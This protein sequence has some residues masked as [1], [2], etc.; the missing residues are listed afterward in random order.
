MTGPSRRQ[1][2]GGVIGAALAMPAR[3]SGSEDVTTVRVANGGP[4]TPISPFVY[5]SNEVGTM[6]GGRP[7]AELDRLAGVTARRFGGNLATT[8]NWTSNAQNAGKDYRHANVDILSDAIGVPAALRNRPGAVIAHTHESSLAMGAITIVTLPVAGYVAADM[9][10]EVTAAETAPSRRFVPVRWA[11]EAR[12]ADP[13]DGSV[14]DIPHLLRRL[15]ER[16]GPAG[17]ATGIRGYALDNEPGLWSQT[18]PRIV[19]RPARIADLLARSIA[20]ARAI[21]AID[22]A[23][24]VIGPASWGA[25]EMATFQDAPDWPDFRRHGSFLAAYLDAF[26]RAS[27]ESGHRLLDVLD[28]HWYPFSRS[29]SLFRTEDPA[30]AGA[31]LDAPRSLDEAGF[32]EDSWVASALP[33]SDEGG[34]ALPILPSLARLA[35][36]GFPGTRIAVG[37]YN[38]GGAGQLASGLALADALGRFGRSGAL[39]AT[40]WGSLEGWLGE[41]FRLYRADGGFGTQALAAR[42]YDPGLVSAFASV[43]PGDPRVQVVAINK[44]TRPRPVDLVLEAPLARPAIQAWGFDADNPRTAPVEAAVRV[45]GGSLRLVLPPRSARRYVLASAGRLSASP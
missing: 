10:G 21:K 28:V 32:R 11:S 18:H 15:V 13:V 29:G 9:A 1:V 2:V 20:A 40:H 7:S 6:D 44:T 34:L 45:D 35:A 4:G 17:S 26:R 16:F 14:A 5:G 8:Y 38:Y 36:Q 37:E 24:W 42:V 43:T 22:P 27:E 12:A 33:V 3:A 19:P 30:L 23:A 25:T 39:L 31:L 41:A